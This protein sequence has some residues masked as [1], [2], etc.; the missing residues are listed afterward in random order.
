MAEGDERPLW[1]SP[2]Q[3]LERVAA[4]G[5]LFAEVQTLR[6]ILPTA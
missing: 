3:A 6:Q 1:F 2:D 5:D 4:I